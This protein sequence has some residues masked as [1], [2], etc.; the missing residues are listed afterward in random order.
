MNA[1][2]LGLHQTI[3]RIGWSAAITLIAAIAGVLITRL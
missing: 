2:I 1:A 3:T